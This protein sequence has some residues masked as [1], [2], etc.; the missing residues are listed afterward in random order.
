MTLL[1][2]A[3]DAAA[4]VAGSWIGIKIALEAGPI[5]GQALHVIAGVLFQLAFAVLL[6]RPIAG[7]LPWL[8][9]LTLQLANEWSDIAFNTGPGVEVAPYIES[10][11]D[12][13]L[14][15]ALPTVLMLIS[16]GHPRVF[17]R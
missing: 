17:V 14:T 10:S 4:S 11:L 16:R 12:T 15:M 9:V 1:R 13:A 5:G 6:R 7:W 2:L 8:G 3:S